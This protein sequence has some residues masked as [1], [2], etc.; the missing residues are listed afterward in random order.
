MH[1]KEN[2]VW[3]NDVRGMK[4]VKVARPFKRGAAGIMLT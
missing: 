2:D 4:D 1:I 3:L